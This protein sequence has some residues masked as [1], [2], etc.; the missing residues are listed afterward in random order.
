M[1][2][3]PVGSSVP[4]LALS[5]FGSLAFAEAP[6]AAPTEAAPPSTAPAAATELPPPP[7][8]EALPAPLLAPPPPTATPMPPPPAPPVAATDEVGPLSLKLGS[9]YITPL[10]FVDFTGMF[11]SNAVGSGIG[12]NFGAIPYGTVYGNSLSESRFSMQNSRLGFRVDVPVLGSH[13]IGYLESD[14][15]GAAPGNVAVSSNSNTLRSRLYWV[16][17]RKGDWEVLAGQTWSL[18]TPGRAGISPLPA[19][20]FYTQDMDVN[21]QAGLVWGR[22]P[23]LRVVYHPSDMFAAAVALD[24]PEQY[25]GGS[26]GGGTV[27][28]PMSLAMGLTNTQLNAG[29][30]TFAVPNVAPD[31][32]VKAAF[33][34]AARF[35]VELGGVERQFKI[36]NPMSDQT[37][38]ATGVGGFLNFNA[39][40]FEGFRLMGNAFVSS[41]GGRYIFGQAPDLVVRADG[42]LSTVKSS[43]TV[44]GVELTLG[45]TLLFAYYGGIYIA[46]NTSPAADGTPCTDATSCVGYGYQGSPNGQNKWIQ[47]AT[48]GLVQTFWKDPKHGALSIIGQYSYLSR[49]PWYVAG[50]APSNAHTNMVFLDL[51]YTLPGAP[52]KAVR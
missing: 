37:F 50:G 1:R 4:V 36:W 40:L 28:L 51:R 2:S 25:I 14:F 48:G 47:E 35:H 38:S 39:Q 17:V 33:D 43:S 26:A 23:E 44:D 52:P 42:S 10:G 18:I 29:N 49:A 34:V 21:Y 7:P 6:P 3:A 46:R 5:L 9:A 11:R 30:S 13:V 45:N 20:V 15:L 27:T 8:A 12:T 19:D 32:I 16:D 24:S 22:I 41:G 31:V